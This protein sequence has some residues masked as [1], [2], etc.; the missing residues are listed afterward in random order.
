MEEQ[1]RRGER[2]RRSGG[3]SQATPHTVVL[4]VNRM[5]REEETHTPEEFVPVLPRSGRRGKL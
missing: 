2:R 5:R 1:D 3:K 4:Q